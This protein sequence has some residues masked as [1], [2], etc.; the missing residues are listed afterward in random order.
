MQTNMGKLDVYFRI[1]VA[2]L[3]G[4]LAYTGFLTGT[5]ATVLLIV[6]VI[7]LATGIIGSCP[8][9]TLFGIRTC[10]REG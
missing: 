3:I 5:L 1:S 6:A 7:F 9:Y 10:S 4:I 2:I 8:L